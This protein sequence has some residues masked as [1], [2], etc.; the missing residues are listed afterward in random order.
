MKAVKVKTYNGC[1]LM[2]ENIKFG[3][4]NSNKFV[5][6]QFDNTILLYDIHQVSK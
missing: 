5:I 2:V 6:T 1:A 4:K 3:Y